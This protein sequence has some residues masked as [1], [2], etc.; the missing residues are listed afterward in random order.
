MAYPVMELSAKVV[1]ANE[2]TS[3]STGT[4]I[5][6]TNSDDGVIITFDPDA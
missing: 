3:A 4:D 5:D 1:A 2:D 6:S